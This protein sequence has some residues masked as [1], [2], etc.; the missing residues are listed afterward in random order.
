ME[1]LHLSQFS[2]FLA[3]RKR[4]FHKGD[5]GHVLIIGGDYGY[6]GAVRLAAEG[7]LRVGAGLVHVVTRPEHALTIPISCPEIMAQSDDN[8]KS[9]LDKATVLAIGPGLGKSAWARK[10]LTLT[11]KYEKPIVIDADGLNLLVEIHT[12]NNNWILTP[13]PG[14]AARLLRKKVEEVQQDRVT[15]VMELQKRYGGV[16]VLKGAGTLI[17]APDSSVEICKAGNPGMATGGMGDL[18]TGMIVGLLAQ[19]LSLER[20]AKLGVLIHAMAGDAA[21][22]EGERGLIASDLFRYIR[23]L[24]NH[25]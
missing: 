19:G 15:S 17:A 13:H 25:E 4:D 9:L 3:P 24:V 1:Q 14:E 16:S 23:K 21:A 6:S 18:L 7:A 12:K 20:A 2:D 10:L 8:I 11:L 22:K 5:A